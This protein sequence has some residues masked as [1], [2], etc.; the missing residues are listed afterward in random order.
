MSQVTR[1]TKTSIIF[2]H[3]LSNH[4][5]IEYDIPKNTTLIIAKQIVL[6]NRFNAIIIGLA[7]ESIKLINIP[8]CK[9][10]HDTDRLWISYTCLIN[11]SL[12]L[13]LDGLRYIA[14]NQCSKIKSKKFTNIFKTKLRHILKFKRIGVFKQLYFT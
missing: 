3:Y 6:R 13:F 7:N 11:I 8:Y 10:W 5:S 4:N 2:E 9:I 14:N 1:K 12:L